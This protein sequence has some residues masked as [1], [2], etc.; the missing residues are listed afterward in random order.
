M[1]QF[2]DVCVW[3]FLYLQA[4]CVCVHVNCPACCKYYRASRVESFLL[5]V[6][7]LPVHM[8][9]CIGVCVCVPLQ[10]S[11]YPATT[12]GSLRPPGLPARCGCAHLFVSLCLCVWVRETDRTLLW[13]HAVTEESR[14]WDM[15]GCQEHPLP[16][17]YRLTAFHSSV[18]MQE[19]SSISSASSCH[20]ESGPS[21]SSTAWY[22][23]RQLLP[24]Y[25]LPC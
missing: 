11:V 17:L 16:T 5:Y 25:F 13:L 23:I 24:S 1:L 20:L 14:L 7:K 3:W 8:C 21:A 10:L 19:H 22:E 6:F 15:P 4:C 12:P 18:W 2:S 9:L